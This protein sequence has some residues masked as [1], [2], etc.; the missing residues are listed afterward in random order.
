M[1]S[2]TNLY[3]STMLK[4]YA[5][6]LKNPTEENTAIPYHSRNL[7]VGGSGAGKSHW[8][9]NY[10]ANSPNTYGRVI[11]CS[12]GIV[13]P[14]YQALGEQLGPSILFRTPEE[15]PTLQMY[16]QDIESMTKRDDEPCQTLLIWDDIVNSTDKCTLKKVREYMCVGRKVGLTQ[17][18]ITQSYFGTDKICR[19]QMTHLI[20]MRLSDEQDLKRILAKFHLGITLSELQEMHASA[21][22]TKFSALKIDMAT[23]N[24]NRRFSKDFV[25]W[26][27][28]SD[29]EEDD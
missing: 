27:Q 19:M 21:T 11:V 10:I 7:V 26:F 15:M 25:Q 5:K 22:K 9:L 4:K 23:S 3:E 29:K 14:I 13:E 18:F 17:F 8:V 2:I 6:K 1:A 20:L 28:I 16:Q 24:P 12:L